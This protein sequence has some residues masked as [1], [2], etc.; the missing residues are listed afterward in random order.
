VPVHPDR[1]AAELLL[2]EQVLA[3]LPPLAALDEVL[4]A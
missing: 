4:V 2:S 3:R 1:E